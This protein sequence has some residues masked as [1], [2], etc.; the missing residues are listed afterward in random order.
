[1]VRNLSTQLAGWHEEKNIG[2]LPTFPDFEG[3]IG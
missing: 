1:M 3:R 2:Q